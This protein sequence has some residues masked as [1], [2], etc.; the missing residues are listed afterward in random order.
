MQAL[1]ILDHGSVSALVASDVPTPVLSAGDVL[2][3]VQAAGINPSDVLSA[4]GGFPD[5]RLPRI[6]GRDFAGVVVDGP[7]NLLG[8]EV[9]G[10]GGD[11]GIARDGTHAEYLAIPSDAVSVRP[12]NL[13]IEEAATVGVPFQTA[14][15][16]LIERGQLKAGEW[17]VISGATG[18]VGTAATQIAAAIGANV[19]ALVRNTDEDSQVLQAKTT[20]IA[21]LD[22]N[23]LGDIV[24]RLTEGRGAD[25]AIN[26]VGE[27]VFHP[28]LDSLAPF[29]RMSLFSVLSGRDTTIDLKQLYRNN[30][31]L[32][33][34]N[35]ATVDVTMGAKILDNLTS[36]F[37]AGTLLVPKVVN[38][39]PFSQA[40]LAYGS[41]A[42][43]KSVLI[44]DRLFAPKA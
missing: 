26:G 32:Y 15:I 5:A 44:P 34:V 40:A 7:Q 9:W 41:L 27:A 30:L 8:L 28:L 17:V 36:L 19:I 24:K 4:Q 38:R 22:T 33:G 35:T 10:S 6:L 31:T 12:K 1:K 42:K 43:G 37:E 3:E 20:A 25:L 29:G 39:Y 23:D 16:A 11:L 13:S 2:I 14:W 18:S 21:H